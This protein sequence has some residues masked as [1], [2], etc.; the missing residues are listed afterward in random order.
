MARLRQLVF[1]TPLILAGWGCVFG[2]N[3][4]PLPPTLGA[5]PAADFRVGPTPAAPTPADLTIPFAFTAP[6]Q[7]AG[8]YIFSGDTVG[9]SA[10]VAE[11]FGPSPDE[12]TQSITGFNGCQDCRWG[13][14]YNLSGLLI[15]SETRP[16]SIDFQGPEF[17]SSIPESGT[18][19][20]PAADGLT[21]RFSEPLDPQTLQDNLQLTYTGAGGAQQVPVA[22]SPSEEAGVY[23]VDLTQAPDAQEITVSVATPTAIT[24]ELGNPLVGGFDALSLSVS[25]PGVEPI[26]C[27]GQGEGIDL[28]IT[29]AKIADG[30]RTTLKAGEGLKIEVNVGSISEDIPSTANGAVLVHGLSTVL[31]PEPTSADIRWIDLVNQ[32]EGGSGSSFSPC[33]SELEEFCLRVPDDVLPGEY[34]VV[35]AIASAG[36]AFSDIFELYPDED[37]SNHFMVLTSTPVTIEPFVQP[38]FDLTV[39]QGPPADIYIRTPFMISL[40]IQYEAGSFSQAPWINMFLTNGSIFVPVTFDLPEDYTGAD[41]CDVAPTSAIELDLAALISD[42]QATP[43]SWEFHIELDPLFDSNGSA[44]I[45]TINLNAADYN[46]SLSSVALSATADFNFSG[47]KTGD[48]LT[49]VF[50]LTNGGNQ[51]SPPLRVSEVTFQ[52]DFLDPDSLFSIDPWCFDNSIPSIDAN[53]TIT[54]ELI[55]DVLPIDQTTILQP[56]VDFTRPHHMRV[57]V[58]DQFDTNQTEIGTL[59][60]TTPVDFLDVPEVSL[61]LVDYGDPVS[62]ADRFGEVTLALENDSAISLNSDTIPCGYVDIEVTAFETTTFVET[63]VTDPFF[64]YFSSAGSASGTVPANGTSEDLVLRMDAS[65]L[66]GGTYDFV[67]RITPFGLPFPVTDRT[68]LEVTLATGVP[69]G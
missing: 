63:V 69:L 43:G 40:S 45:T 6:E 27:L 48:K 64:F 32:G 3:S 30:T 55:L 50:D 18:T 37:T 47:L 56:S 62:S 28:A 59:E 5:V 21:L 60:T 34:Y 20:H 61:T 1:L 38:E 53:D 15:M 68:A 49:A 66:P 17:L 39:T 22:I 57:R 46:V 19:N 31:N 23:V 9:N 29:S 52:S 7:E 25:N 13:V 4:M 11:L 35:L 10:P 51:P 41:A 65:S 14:A 54:H 16:I 36:P 42:P 44:N 67:A 8:V 12:Q 26:S 33:T 58:I 24:D 2:A